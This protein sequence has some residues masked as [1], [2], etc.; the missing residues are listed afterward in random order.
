MLQIN[1]YSVKKGNRTSSY[2]VGLSG[3]GLYIKWNQIQLENQ[4]IVGLHLAYCFH[5]RKLMD[6]GSMFFYD[7]ILIVEDKL[8]FVQNVYYHETA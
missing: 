2:L 7:L 6:D 5:L 4:S 8:Y 1:R 3:Y